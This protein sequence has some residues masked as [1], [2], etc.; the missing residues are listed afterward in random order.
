[1]DAWI[2]LRLDFPSKAGNFFL[3]ILETFP[4][5]IRLKIAMLFIL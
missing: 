3:L 1:M 5:D 4:A 2:L